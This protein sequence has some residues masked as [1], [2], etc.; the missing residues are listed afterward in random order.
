MRRRAALESR[1]C[2]IPRLELTAQDITCAATG[3]RVLARQAQAQAKDPQLESCQRL[4]ED[5]A[6]FYDERAEV[7]SDREAVSRIRGP[8]PG[9]T[10]A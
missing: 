2:Q 7:R 10:I 1:P 3:L 6:K 5:S 9:K 4:F 8:N